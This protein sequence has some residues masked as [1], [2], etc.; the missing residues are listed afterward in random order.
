MYHYEGRDIPDLKH[1][2]DITG[3]SQC[4]GGVVK[5]DEHNKPTKETWPNMASVRFIRMVA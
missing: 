2:P 3:C 4:H 5:M 1:A